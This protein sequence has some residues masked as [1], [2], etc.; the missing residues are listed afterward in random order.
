[1]FSNLP[2]SLQRVNQSDCRFE[3]VQGKKTLFNT[4]RSPEQAEKT[5]GFEKDNSKYN[6]ELLDGV[7]GALFDVLAKRVTRHVA[8][9]NAALLSLK[10]VHN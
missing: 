4:T 8:R 6:T 10:L 5:T 7:A 2:L 9:A 3:E 1:M